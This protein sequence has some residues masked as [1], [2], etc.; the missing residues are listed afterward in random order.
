MK[1]TNKI[2][3]KIVLQHKPIEITKIL[4]VNNNKNYENY[5]KKKP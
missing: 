5:K 3:K 4:R 1:A 2:I